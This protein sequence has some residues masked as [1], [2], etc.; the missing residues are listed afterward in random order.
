[1]EFVRAGWHRA[2][3]RVVD[4]I[5]IVSNSIVPRASPNG[6][7]KA[8]GRKL[9]VKQAS[10]CQ[11]EVGGGGEGEASSSPIPLPPRPFITRPSFSARAALRKRKRAERRAFGRLILS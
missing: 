7:E 8:L 3:T 11:M 4:D 9:L 5:S 10:L 6:P 1:M 2:H